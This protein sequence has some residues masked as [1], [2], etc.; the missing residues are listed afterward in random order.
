MKNN[1]LISISK[2][3]RISG[4]SARMLRYYDEKG[5]LEPADYS[6]SGQRLYDE[7]ALFRLQVISSFSYLGYSADQ[8]RD[9]LQNVNQ[10][11]LVTVFKNQRK[12]LED[13][14]EKLNEVIDVLSGV[15]EKTERNE[16]IS[17]DD[18]VRLI[19]LSKNSVRLK[20]EKRLKIRNGAGL[21]V[22]TI[23]QG[24]SFHNWL[25][26]IFNNMD[27]P[28]NA[29]IAEFDAGQ[30]NV[31]RESA[32]RMAGMKVDSWY[33]E[34]VIPNKSGFDDSC[35]DINWKLYKEISDIPDSH[36]DVI[37]DTYVEY[38]DMPIDEWLHKI[39]DKL[40]PG[41]RFYSVCIDEEHK[42]ELSKWCSILNPSYEESRK[43]RIELYGLSKA[44][45]YISEMTD[46]IRIV[47]KI[48]NVVVD[49][50]D[51]LIKQI[52][53]LSGYTG[54]SEN[55]RKQYAKLCRLISDEF[56]KNGKVEFDSHHYLVEGVK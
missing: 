51:E 50:M 35:L 43:A 11:D 37:F 53:E 5:I 46:K 54:K 4:I 1:E 17:L 49:D 42:R 55:S 14:R 19:S 13:E 45:D 24:N 10:K 23:S 12:M 39:W 28:E 21:R 31:W 16:E 40:K 47:P 8:I 7:S 30:A 9:V 25:T 56:K 29:Y 26:W 44:K 22:Y 34:N 6:E 32:L 18:T 52:V 20:P 2:L 27:I 36:Y 15:I 48:D 38:H 41:G 33:Q 3:S